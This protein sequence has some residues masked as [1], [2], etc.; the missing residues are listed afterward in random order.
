MLFLL[1]AFAPFI[2]VSGSLI[3][4]YS[5]PN[6]SAFEMAMMSFLF[7]T[8]LLGYSGKM[9]WLKQ[10]WAS[11]RFSSRSLILDIYQKNNKL[12]IFKFYQKQHTYTFRIDCH[13]FLTCLRIRRWRVHKI[14]FP[15]N[16][17]F[18]LYFITMY[19]IIH[20]PV[21]SRKTRS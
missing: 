7:K 10:V 9:S 18:S 5:S 3:F 16:F 20:L 2:F 11:G 17:N 8:S 6:P 1:L 19:V 4:I 15:K 12:V 14:T 13:I 21:T